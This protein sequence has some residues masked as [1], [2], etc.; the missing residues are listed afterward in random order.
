MM[1]VTKCILFAAM[2]CAHEKRDIVLI[3]DGSA[4]VGYRNVKKVK[5]F[6]Q[7]L[8]LELNVGKDYNRLALVQFSEKDKTSVEFGFDRYYEA[9]KIVRAISKMHYHSG[10]M[11]MTGHALALAHDKVLC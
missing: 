3:V 2:S 6:L 7:K 9:R 10:Q 5:R 4:S 8:V 11:T 1:S